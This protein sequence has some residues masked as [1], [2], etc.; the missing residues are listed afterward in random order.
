MKKEKP[1]IQR[2]LFR[3]IVNGFILFFAGVVFLLLLLFGFS[4]TSTFR[5]ILRTKVIAIAD[6]SLNGQVNIG[7]I[8]GTIFTSL[9]LNDVSLK[10]KDDTLFSAKSIQVKIS[11]LQLMLKRIYFRSVRIINANV[12]LLQN[13]DSTWNYTN[14]VPPSEED[15]SSSTFPFVFYVNNLSLENLN[16]RQQTYSER[17]SEEIYP[18]F[19][20]ADL[21][22]ENINLSARAVIDL[23]TP[24]YLL[25]IRDFSFSPNITN[26]ALKKFAGEFEISKD[27]A[28]IKDF[29]IVTQQSDISLSLRADNFHLFSGFD[30]DSLKTAPIRV[31]LKAAPFNFDDLSAFI[32]STDLLK[33]EVGVSLN[34]EGSLSSL[35]IEHLATEYK[36]THFEL[37]GKV[38]NIVDA[39]KLYINADLKNSTINYDDVL[40]LLPDL[41]L[42]KFDNVVLNNVSAKFTGFPDKFD[43]KV[44]ADIDKGSIS[45]D[46]SLDL[47]PKLMKYN[48]AFSTTSFNAMPFLGVPTNL[49]S[50]GLIK[51]T[52]TQP[53][54]MIADLSVNVGKSVFNYNNV[55]AMKVKSSAAAGLIDMLI[56]GSVNSSQTS[57]KADFNFTDKD[58]PSYKLDG[59]INNL[60]L[61][62]FLKD[63]SYSSKLNFSLSAKGKNFN[64]DSLNA[65]LAIKLEPSTF[66]TNKIEESE[67]NL[68][69][70]TDE[71]VRKIKLTSDFVDFNIHGNFSLNNA[72]N[73]VTYESDVISKIIAKKV[74]EL[75]P[76][77]VIQDTVAVEDTLKEVPA[78]IDSSLAF[79]YDFT[80]KDF[81][82]IA[83]I[84]GNDRLDIV[85]SGNGS[86]KNNPT[87]FSI[88]T[89]FDID[90]FVNQ[91]KDKLFYISDLTADFNFIRNNRSLSFD[92]LFGTAS[93]TGK[94]L[95]SGANIKNIAA[96]VVFNQSK[97][98]FNTHVDIDTLLQSD[99]EGTITMNA[100]YQKINLTHLV[101]N[102]Q[103]LEWQNTDTMQVFFS[104]DE[105]KLHNF[106]VKHGNSIVNIDGSVYTAD[107]QNV[108]LTASHISG[109]VIGKYLLNAGERDIKADL[110][111]DASLK[112]TFA[113]PLMH[114][115]LNVNKIAYENAEFGYLVGSL[116]YKNKNLQTDIRFLDTTYNKQDPELVLTGNIPVDLS[117]GTIE[118]RFVS[119]KS[120]DLIFKSTQFK[121]GALGNVLPIISQQKG[122]LVADVK[123]GGTISDPVYTGNIGI[124]DASFRLRPNNMDYKFGCNLVFNQNKL[125]ISQFALS[126]NGGTNYGGTI[127]GSGE[128][129]FSGIKLKSIDLKMNGDLAVLG[130]ASKAVNPNF[131]GDLKISTDGDWEYTYANERSFFKG[132]ILLVHTNITYV[133]REQIANTSNGDFDIRIIADSSKIDKE[134]LNFQKILTESSNKNN[135]T[136]TEVAS[137]NFDY[138]IN[139]KIQNDAKLTFI[140]SPA[141]NQKLIVEARGDMTYESTN[142][143]TRAQGV[144]DVL[145]GSRLEFFKTF[146]ATGSLRFES[147]ITNPYLDIVATYTGEYTD[148]SN[149]IEPVAVKIKLKGTLDDLGKNLASN[150][151]N[152]GV[153]VGARDIANDVSDP[154]YDYADAFSFVLIGKFK[155][156]LTAN[157]KNSLASG[158]AFDIKNT[159]TSFL[160]PVLTGFVN[161]AVGDVV[162]NIQV[163]EYN[164]SYKFSISGKVQNLRYSFGG[165]TDKLKD[166]NQATLRLEYLFNP[167]FLIR[168]ERKDPIVEYYSDEQKISELGLKY[169]F[170]F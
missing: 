47:Q 105:I 33:G 144:F 68:S 168:L 138:H 14:L 164:N 76:L 23:K 140:L 154:A 82:L 104:P 54:N 70:S 29:N 5:E 22:V 114:V 109:D 119:S 52:G 87:N 69:L 110:N 64:L 147:D 7:K 53:N 165:V 77:A 16:F 3:K 125:N 108:A 156:D 129:E 28:S 85:G 123:I 121:L 34:A 163:G 79:D 65:D 41:D 61:A 115:E 9:F 116:D 78:I 149:Q 26:V 55:E 62:E 67:L 86:V 18:M 99:A 75:N 126:N 130:S 44:N 143:R 98:F 135:N 128:I 157:D 124:S 155:S 45:V 89:E 136:S 1:K 32:E 63:S 94:R 158:S 151:D 92:K 102:Y 58:H 103:N 111:I 127:N 169:K 38:N 166:I 100:D 142:G 30:M 101:L 21:R 145:S 73:L 72:V 17:G 113:S 83:S 43:A 106:S 170:E 12:A 37:S 59:K 10:V 141:L 90:Y 131:Y 159:A 81:S 137:L 160:G 153:Y 152:I 60:N 95:Y 162:N 50:T 51:G 96:D 2:S 161:S 11:P 13:A 84:M 148:K 27:F 4:Q 39:G 93:L 40:G 112:G 134:Y 74:D 25:V 150:P 118:E 56:N 24:D 49:N 167:N 122:T 133:S 88:S 42:P 36:G 57:L 146:D 66:Q 80:F 35:D 117:F 19:N 107:S 15:T 91:Y 46:G 97:L 31:K 132:N 20:D 139:V 8:E 6:S 71:Q 120:I 48:F